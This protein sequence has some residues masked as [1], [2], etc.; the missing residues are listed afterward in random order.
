MTKNDDK[1]EHN[2]ADL[3]RELPPGNVGG[4]VARSSAQA[5][6][7]AA[8]TQSGDLERVQQERDSLLDRLARLQA[9]FENTR[10]RADREREQFKEFALTEALKSLLPVLD[11]F[12]Q[13]LGSGRLDVEEFRSGVNLIRRQFEDVL[14]KLGVNQIQARGSTFDPHMHHAVEMVDTTSASDGQ[15]LEELQRGYKLRDR[16]LRPAMVR[17]AQNS[18]SD[19]EQKAA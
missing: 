14:S 10:K 18:K 15:V 19:A 9:E 4:D 7:Q 13:A 17:V 6:A 2:T 8:A 5:S 3:E 1:S 11:S 12:D 16:V